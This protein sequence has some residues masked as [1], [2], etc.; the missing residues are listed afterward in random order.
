MG[1]LPELDDKVVKVSVLCPI[2]HA[3]VYNVN[4]NHKR[5]QCYLFTAAAN[6]CLNC[7]PDTKPSSNIASLRKTG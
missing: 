6:Y 3:L 7:V 4:L 2:S 1:E 5:A